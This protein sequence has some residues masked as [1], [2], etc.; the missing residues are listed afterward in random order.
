MKEERKV[1][2]WYLKR[3]EILARYADKYPSKYDKIEMRFGAHDYGWI[4]FHI[5][6]NGESI[7]LLGLS[8]LYDPFVPMK[9][10]LEGIVEGLYEKVS[11]IKLDCEDVYTIL[12]FEPL[13]FTYNFNE[14]SEV[15]P[16]HSGIF[17]VYDSVRKEFVVDAFCDI[18]TLVR[19]L[20]RN[21]L[22]FAEKM[23]TDPTFADDWAYECWND[24]FP[25]FEDDD[26]ERHDFFYNKMKSPIIE[27][28]LED[29]ERYRKMSQER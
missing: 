13:W 1:N 24:E 12:Y 15:N 21:I 20:Y 26:P 18:E 22:D 25:A 23:K 6:K 11:V 16:F 14:G 9:R 29:C 2:N 19:D 8:Y 10:W 27:K 17:L 28:Y 5:I 7:E 3:S 4:P